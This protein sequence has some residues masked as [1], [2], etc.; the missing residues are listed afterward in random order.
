MK[1]A[2]FGGG[3]TPGPVPRRGGGR[4]GGS[5]ERTPTPGRGG[6]NNFYNDYYP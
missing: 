1:P 3:P 2:K 4:R 5:R 6:E